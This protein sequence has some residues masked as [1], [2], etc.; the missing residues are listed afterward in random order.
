MDLYV[1]WIFNKSCFEMFALF[2]NGFY[3]VLKSEIL[4]LFNANELMTLVAG[5]VTY[6]FDNNSF[7][8]LIIISILREQLEI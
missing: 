8:Q 6:L 7:V 2:A 3:R 5:K 1:D 4:S